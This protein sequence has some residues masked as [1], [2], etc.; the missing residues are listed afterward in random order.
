MQVG[1][2]FETGG[3]GVSVNEEDTSDFDVGAWDDFNV[4]FSVLWALQDLTDVNVGAEFD[5]GGS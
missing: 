2:D 4:D 1:D 3:D 5:A